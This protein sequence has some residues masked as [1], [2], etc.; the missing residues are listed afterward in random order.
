MAKLCDHLHHLDG[1][2]VE[3][4]N[5]YM[6]SL[7]CAVWVK[8]GREII[9]RGGGCQLKALVEPLAELNHASADFVRR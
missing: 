1:V 6:C 2:C 5:E 4:A 7:R 3:I 8:E 9:R